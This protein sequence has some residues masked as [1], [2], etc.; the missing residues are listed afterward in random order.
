MHIQIE[1]ITNISSEVNLRFGE[2]W[3]ISE[4]DL[5]IRKF[6]KNCSVKTELLFIAKDL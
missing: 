1:Y 6:S 5:L 3:K 4:K 2:Y